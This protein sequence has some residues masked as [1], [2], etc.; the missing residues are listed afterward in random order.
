MAACEA[1]QH[2]HRHAIIHRDIKPSNILVTEG[3]SV[4]LLDFGV[5]K[6]LERQDASADM[7]RT[8]SGP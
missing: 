8:G 1:V 2:A 6:H 4:K 7:T 5:A 3:G